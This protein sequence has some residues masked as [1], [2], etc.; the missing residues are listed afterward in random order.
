MDFRLELLAASFAAILCHT[1]AF[2][3]GQW[4]MYGTSLLKSLFIIFATIAL[5]ESL[6]QGLPF[7]SAFMASG[8]VCSTY[9][10]S[11]FV[12]IITYRTLFHRLHHFPGPALAKISKL[13]HVAHCLGSKNHLLLDGVHEEYVDF[14]RTGTL[15]D[16]QR[17]FSV[18]FTGEKTKFGVS[19]ANEITIFAPDVLRTIYG[20]PSNPFS[21]PAWYDILQPYAG[22]TS[23]RDRKVHEYH[24]QVW[25]YRFT[26]RGLLHPVC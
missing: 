21:K 26:N 19:G 1:L 11:L 10:S 25:D 14:V 12:S 6:Y 13:W 2:V 15:R 22:L 16:F 17:N 3:H 8:G 4:H 7:A 20:G 5:L 18:A 23:H 24:R 9:L